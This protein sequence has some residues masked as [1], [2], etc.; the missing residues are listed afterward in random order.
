MPAGETWEP[1]EW[2]GCSL[3]VGA[4][5]PSDDTPVRWYPTAEVTPDAASIPIAVLEQGCAGGQVAEGR[6]RPPVIEYRPDAVLISVT[7]E[8]AGGFQTC[9]GNP[10]TP[11]VLELTEPL[12]DRALL[13]GG[14]YPPAPPA[15]PNPPPPPLRDLS[16]DAL[17]PNPDGNVT[18]LVA[19][20]SETVDPVEL[21]HMI[22]GAVLPQAT[23]RRD[24]GWV[25]YRFDLP[26][27]LHQISVGAVG[28]GGVGQ[29]GMED[30]FE[31]TGQTWL[32]LRFSGDG[33]EGSLTF[34]AHDEP[35]P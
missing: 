20:E 12:G 28:P 13:D 26:P 30:F 5:P 21:H 35:P 9:P 8:P 32:V 15:D 17:Q 31:V 23:H 29:D 16:L 25:E 33:G 27:G 14:R 2:S 24:Q 10:P 1:T 19:N 34:S 3:R 4:D 11:Y 6:V 7:V 22:T 18:F